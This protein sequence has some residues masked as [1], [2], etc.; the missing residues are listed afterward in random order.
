MA[1]YNGFYKYWAG[2]GDKKPS[3]PYKIDW[4]KTW[5]NWIERK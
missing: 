3:D 1:K 2:K 4:V 5:V